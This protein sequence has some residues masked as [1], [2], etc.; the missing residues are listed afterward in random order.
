MN[1]LSKISKN[2]KLLVLADQGVFSGSNF[3][4]TILFARILSP[5]DFGVFT[6]I[7]LYNYL[8]ISISNSIVIQPLQVIIAKIES[9]ASYLSFT[10]YSQLLIV[11][12]VSIFTYVFLQF[13][14]EF[15]KGLK[16]HAASIILYT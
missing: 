2:R 6:S 15:I 9:K 10:F 4:T 16:D 3:V 11:L 8:L 7:V 14:V 5:D 1:L 13:E 12:L